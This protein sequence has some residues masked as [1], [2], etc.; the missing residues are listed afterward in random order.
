M[1][2]GPPARSLPPVSPRYPQQTIPANWSR[3]SR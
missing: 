2:G 1:W 3:V